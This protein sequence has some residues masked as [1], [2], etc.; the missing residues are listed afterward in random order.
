M[1]RVLLGVVS[2]TLDARA[3][4]KLRAIR[5]SLKAHR[6]IE[7]GRVVAC[8]AG[9]LFCTSGL[10]DVMAVWRVTPRL[11]VFGVLTLGLAQWDKIKSSYRWL[12][13]TAGPAVVTCS[14]V[15]IAHIPFFHVSKLEWR[16]ICPC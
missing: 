7:I 4:T 9:T 5:G 13:I 3:I 15:V 11:E 8:V 1:I 14:R 12:D 2:I 10:T 6:E 16:Q